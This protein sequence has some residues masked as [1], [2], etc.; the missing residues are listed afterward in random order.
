MGIYFV[1]LAAPPRPGRV[2]YDRAGSAAASMTTDHVDWEAF[3]S[4]RVVHLTGTTPALSASCREVTLEAARRARQAAC[5]LTIDL[6]YRRSLWEPEEARD[7]LTLLCEGADVV[8]AAERDLRFVF[9]LEGDPAKVFKEAHRIL[10]AGSFIM[11][12]GDQGSLWQVLDEEGETPAYR[13]QV[14]DR[15][16]CGDAFAAG[17]IVGLL[18]GDVE[19]GIRYGTA[20][21]ALTL[22]WEG[23]QFWGDL[24]EVER[25]LSDAGS[26][27]RR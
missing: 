15:V 3:T 5:S 12:R 18:R 19:A 23:D 10:Q 16:G 1:E 22:G 20:M 4:A 11:T 7:V 14:V 17:V 2:I 9:G 13:V 6:N 24:E 26:E 21:A 27:I 8:L 25:L